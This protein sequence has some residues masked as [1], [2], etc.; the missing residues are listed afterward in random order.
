MNKLNN[1]DVSVLH[2][3]S[4]RCAR[5]TLDNTLV[6]CC[7]VGY[8]KEAGSAGEHEHTGHRAGDLLACWGLS[9]LGRSDHLRVWN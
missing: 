9:S 1:Q 7:D 8:A 6:P 4:L 3:T 2:K 5:N